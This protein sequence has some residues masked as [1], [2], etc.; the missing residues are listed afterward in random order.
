MI[1][2]FSKNN[3]DKRVRIILVFDTIL[4]IAR[5]MLKSNESI[6]EDINQK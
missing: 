4:L 1:N 2:L 5:Q 6:F 3:F